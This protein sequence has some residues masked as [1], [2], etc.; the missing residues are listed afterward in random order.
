MYIS[1]VSIDWLIDWELDQ[2]VLDLVIV[3]LI[4]WS[5]VDWVLLIDWLRVDCVHWLIDWLI[6]CWLCTLIDWLSGSSVLLINRVLIDWLIE[7]CIVDRVLIDW[8]ILIECWLSVDWVLHWLIER[9]RTKRLDLKHTSF[10]WI[11]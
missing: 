6:E 10:E 7:Y 5:S 1:C 3:W 9:R 2:S 8:L 11:N 4:D